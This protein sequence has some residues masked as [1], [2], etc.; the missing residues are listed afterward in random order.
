MRTLCKP[1]GLPVFPPHDDAGGDCVLARLLAEEPGRAELPWPAGFEG[2]LAHRLD[3]STSG[4]L[5]VADDLA[6]LEALRDRFARKAL[7]KTYVLRAARDV[8]WDEHVVEVALAHDR[9]RKGRMVAQRGA[10]TAHRGRWIPARTELTR[11]AG[12]LWRAEMRTGVMHQIRLHCAFVGLP[13]LGDRLYGGGPTP[14]D[15]PPGVTF[16]LHHVGLQGEGIATS[17]V[18]APS[19]ASTTV[20]GA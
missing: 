7:L 14:P 13:L 17:P 9:R 12:D 16:F 15:A 6:E 3:T 19:W 1:A 20:T 11:I 18:P 2:G 8:P 5:A 10:S 4:A